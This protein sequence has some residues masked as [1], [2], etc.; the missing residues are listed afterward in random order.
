[1]TS[2]NTKFVIRCVR[3]GKTFTEGFVPRC[4]SCDG[5]TDVSFLQSQRIRE[6]ESNPMR[7]YFDFMPV[8][9]IDRAIWL[10]APEPTPCIHAKNLGDVIGHSLV[11]LKDETKHP[12]RT[13]KDRMASG[14]FSYFQEIG[15]WEFVSSSTGNS[16]TSFAMGA[17]AHPEFTIHLYCG[18][19]FLYAMNWPDYP[20][21]ELYVLAGA[22]FVEAFDFS[23]QA[24]PAAG[25]IME[26]GF[27]NPARRCGLKLAFFEAAEQI[28]HPIDWYFQATSSGMGVFGTWMGAQ[29]LT[30]A[31]VIP[32][33]PRVVCIQ[34]DT[35]APQVNAWKDG[36]GEILPEHI[37]PLPTGPARAIMR[38]D[39]THVYPYMRAIVR[40]SGGTFESV[41]EQEILDAQRLIQETE[42]IPACAASACT[43]AGLRKLIAQGMVSTQETVML[44]ITGADREFRHPKHYTILERRPDGWAESRS[45]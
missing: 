17:G 29:E 32:R 16:S 25:R 21:V 18:E 14:V 12:T 41:S 30:K 11:Y 13:T 15:L 26:R 22:T 39:P 28:P 1:V 34:Q 43:L 2:E 23:R 37:V 19:D 35:C 27:F 40:E 3:C 44:N 6:A 4:L 8:L 45:V 42:G 20:N 24:G 38:G 36:S 31:G 33:P 9:D 5:A 7:R 10:G